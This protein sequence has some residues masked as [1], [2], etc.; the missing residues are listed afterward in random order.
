[1]GRLVA[2]TWT[3]RFQSVCESNGG[4]IRRRTMKSVLK[5]YE[6]LKILQ[7]YFFSSDLHVVKGF[8]SRIRSMDGLNRETS[9]FRNAFSCKRLGP[10][11]GVKRRALHKYESKKFKLPSSK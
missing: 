7:F 10:H 4:E 11:V 1:M 2:R 9:F 5:I 3:R 6:P 8:A